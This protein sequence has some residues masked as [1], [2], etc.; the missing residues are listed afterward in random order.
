MV[1]F[2][3]R[4]GDG[5]LGTDP[6]PATP[7][8]PQPGGEAQ[9]LEGLLVRPTT[10]VTRG[11]GCSGH[12]YS[13]PQ[14]STSV[15]LDSDTGDMS[16]Q[17]SLHDIAE[18]MIAEPGYKN[19]LKL[20]F[21]FFRGVGDVEADLAGLIVAEPPRVGDS[22]FDAI[23][24]ASAEYVAYHHG[25]PVPDWVYDDCRFLRYGWFV[26]EYLQAQRWAMAF[27]PAA[28]KTRGVYLEER[29]LPNI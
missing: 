26:P 18:L 24:A 3:F 6:A 21:E 9:P 29:D 16:G 4:R 17:L 2:S 19:R 12:R 1:G 27:A 5:G 11:C 25:L 8:L 13:L 22:R 20:V 7:P 28:F 23:L 15:R 14:V 10:G